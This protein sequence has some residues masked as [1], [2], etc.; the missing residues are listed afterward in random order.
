MD[1]HHFNSM[2][3]WVKFHQMASPHKVIQHP[4]VKYGGFW[5]SNS[6]CCNTIKSR[7]SHLYDRT[8]GGN[9]K[10]V[11]PIPPK[12][13]GIHFV[14]H[15]CWWLA[16]SHPPPFPSLLHFLKPTNHLFLPYVSF[17]CH[18]CLLPILINHLHNVY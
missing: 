15:W 8:K 14:I 4:F 17:Y 12:V 3:F 9:H 2:F 5:L 16:T 18:P 1:D 10:G 6:P 7:A 11:E 13:V